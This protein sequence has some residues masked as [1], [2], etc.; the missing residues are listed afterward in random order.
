MACTLISEEV[1]NFAVF[2]TAEWHKYRTMENE[3]KTKVAEL[4][5]EVAEQQEA[6][7]TKMEELTRT[8]QDIKNLENVYNHADCLIS[9]IHCVEHY[10]GLAS[11]ELDARLEKLADTVRELEPIILAHNAISLEADAE[12]DTAFNERQRSILLEIKDLKTELADKI[13]KLEAC[14]EEHFEWKTRSSICEHGLANY[15]MLIEQDSE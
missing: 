8:A 3:L 13:A 7:N 15:K 6:L 14:K 5:R 2:A 1:T 9:N 10:K 11:D 4:T 12:V